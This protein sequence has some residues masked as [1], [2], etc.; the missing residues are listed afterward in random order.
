MIDGGPKVVGRTF[1]YYV[2]L[3][4]VPLPLPT[5]TH[6][7]HPQAADL[8][9]EHRPEPVPPVSRRL[10]A[11]LYAPFGQGI[12][13]V[14]QRKRKPDVHHYR[15]ADDLGG[16]FEVTKGARWVISPHY[17]TYLH[18]STDLPLTLPWRAIE[19]GNPRTELP[20]IGN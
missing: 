4:Q 14:L 8:C 3:A 2:D 6:R 16:R 9:G 18:A 17:V 20:T 7:F 5:R 13:D 19:D 10:M 15:R 12:L 11:D 1:D